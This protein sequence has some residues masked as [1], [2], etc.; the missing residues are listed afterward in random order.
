MKKLFG[1]AII[2]LLFLGGCAPTTQQADRVNQ[3]ELGKS[4]VEKQ[5]APCHGIKTLQP[6][7]DTLIV[8][9]PDLATIQKRRGAVSFPIV[10]V[11]KII[12]GREWINAHGTRNMPV[13]GEVYK[14]EGLDE[15]E[16]LGKKGAIIAYLMSI[17]QE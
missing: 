6:T 17:Q 9:A 3:I 12:D 10:E 13:W 7:I 2:G 11:A 15:T 16:I 1:V 5:C 14:A 4:I 8:P